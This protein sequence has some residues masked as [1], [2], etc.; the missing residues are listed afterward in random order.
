MPVLWRGRLGAE[1]GRVGPVGRDES[2]PNGTEEAEPRTCV[3]AAVGKC[4]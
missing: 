4:T 1:A 2:C 3:P